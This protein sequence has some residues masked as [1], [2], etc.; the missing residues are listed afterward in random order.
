[1]ALAGF[2]VGEAE[3]L[4]RA[5]SRKRSRDAME[6]WR[7]RFVAGA[8]E[9]GV[10]TDLANRIYDKLAGFSGFGFPEVALRRLR[11]ARLPVGVAAPPLPGRVPLRAP[12][13]AADGLL[14]AREPRPRRPAAR[15][16]GA[17]ARRQP[18]ARAK[19]TD[20][21]RRSPDRARLHPR[22]S[23]RRRPRR[24]RPGSPTRTSSISPSALPS[25]GRVLHALV[26]AGRL[27]LLRDPA[28]RA[29]LAPGRRAP[30]RACS[31]RRPPACAPARADRA[32]PG[33]ARPDR[34]GADARRLRDDG[35][36]GRRRTRSS[37]CA[38]TCLRRTLSS[39]AELAGHPGGEVA[40]A[41]PRR[42]PPAARDRERG[43]LHAARGRDRADEP[44]RPAAGLR[45]LPRARPR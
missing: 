25:P 44:D 2:S 23:A 28:P 13:R 41:G 27:R 32:R 18:A 37:S 8:L 38:R 17:P 31:R 19:C 20:R 42:R 24:S 21:G 7:E 36:L 30:A 22:R 40:V 16:G 6:A 14:P 33:P 29:P 26:A 5:M 12:E 35:P 15:G 10:D 4:R 43:R 45:A 34:L 11:A 1:M 9:T 3:G 39:S